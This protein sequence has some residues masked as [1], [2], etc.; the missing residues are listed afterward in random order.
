METKKVTQIRTTLNDHVHHVHIHHLHI[1]HVHIHRVHVHHG[2]YCPVDIVH[3]VHVYQVEVE[4]DD[5]DG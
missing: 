5:V 3:H 2:Y 4:V 1:Y